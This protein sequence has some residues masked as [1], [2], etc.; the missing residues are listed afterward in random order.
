MGKGKKVTENKRSILHSSVKAQ[1][2]IKAQ[3]NSHSRNWIAEKHIQSFLLG[4]HERAAFTSSSYLHLMNSALD[5]PGVYSCAIDSFIELVYYSLYNKLKE[6]THLSPM[7]H[8][9]FVSCQ[10][11]E[12]I[13][14]NLSLI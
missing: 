9:L 11:Y 3:K 6:L 10:D 1:G 4:N 7:I 5:F 13:F 8:R 14:N 12:G 2:S